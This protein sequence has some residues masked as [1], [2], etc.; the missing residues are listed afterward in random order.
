MH[1]II[2]LLILVTTI[3]LGIPV[4][5]CFMAAALYMGLVFF[6][7][8]SFL[9]TVGFRGLNS[10]TLLSIPFFIMAGAL[11]GS[12]GIAEKLTNFANS[13]LGRIR[14]GMG[15]ATIVACAI[16][17]AISGTASSAVACIGTI[18]IP[19]LEELG[20]P[21]NYSTAMV[22]CAAVLGQLIPP[23]VPMILYG[24]VTQ[25]SVAAC[26]L[27][28]VVPGVLTM[29][30]FCVI[31]Y[32][33]CKKFPNLQVGKKISKK[34]RNQ[35]IFVATKKGFWSLLMPFI[36]LGGIYGGIT[37]PT[38]SAAVAVLYA[39][40]VG[41][42]IHKELKMDIL[43]EAFHNSATTSGVIVLMLFFVTIL[44]RLYTMQ[45]V[46]MM[47]ADFLLG[48]SDNKFVILFMVNI[49]LIII[50]MLMD[51][52]SG[53]MLV[54]PLLMPLIL[55]IGVHPI[56]FA[57][58]LGTNLG[59]GNVTPP[60]APILYLGGRIGGVNIDEYI[61]PALIFMIFGSIPIV[62]LTTYVPGLSLFLPR[63]IMGIK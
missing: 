45:R 36:I 16:F 28:T 21:R 22:S 30:L 29:T 2:D 50:G 54:A 51:D 48:V 59:L 1:I 14:G 10:L 31:N 39:T 41:F 58:I 37:T 34:E 35:E 5:F 11:M 19:R 32:F 53:T 27:S 52:L 20:Y 43:G 24:W 13:M 23:S 15:A 44:G 60:T 8:F 9:M 56:H 17:G 62:L 40:L 55:K 26:F 47:V 4:P 25:Q 6:P 61:K 57:A 3:I 46:P 33:M 42:F 38:E 49:F 12:A 18:M 7:D 63:L